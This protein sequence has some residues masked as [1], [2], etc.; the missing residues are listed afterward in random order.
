MRDDVHYT[1]K[2]DIFG[3][4]MFIT[5]VVI[6]GCGFL[7]V[8]KK[9]LI[10]LVG[11]AVITGSVTLVLADLVFDVEEWKLKSYAVVTTIIS[12]IILAIYL[13]G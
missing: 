12:S 4:V 1:R 6:I 8:G 3:L 10:L 13:F 2:Q 5:W 9:E 11:F 7:L